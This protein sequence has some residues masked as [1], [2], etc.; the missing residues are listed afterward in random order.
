MAG[1]CQEGELLGFSFEDSS[2]DC[3][4]A[5][6]NAAD[7][8]CAFYTFSPDDGFCGQY[9]TCPTISADGC[10]NCVSGTFYM[11]FLISSIYAD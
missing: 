3:L 6:K 9:A 5:C 11:S 7:A 8:G 2:A 10:P 4:E 1:E